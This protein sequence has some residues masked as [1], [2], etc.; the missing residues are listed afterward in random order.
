L[1]YTLAV[2]GTVLLVAAQPRAWA[3]PVRH[4]FLHQI[5][6]LGVDSVGFVSGVAVFVGITVVWPIRSHV[7][8]RRPDARRAPSEVV[9]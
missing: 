2:I 6:V 3:H 7:E 5:V 4:A 8:P 1:R 9:P